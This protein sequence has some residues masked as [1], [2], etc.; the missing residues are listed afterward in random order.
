MPAQGGA[1][2]RAEDVT[3]DEHEPDT[4]RL[5]TEEHD[6]E[7][8]EHQDWATDGCTTGEEDPSDEDH[9]SDDSHRSDRK[10]SSEL[11]TDLENGEEDSR[12]DRAGRRHES[13]RLLPRTGVFT[14]LHAF[15]PVRACHVET[16]VDDLLR[17]PLLP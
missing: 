1:A 7:H 13:D 10:H 5:T 12:H 11:T 9:P 2:E 15:L 3:G 16:Q 8:R 4:T 6:G 14:R 17:R